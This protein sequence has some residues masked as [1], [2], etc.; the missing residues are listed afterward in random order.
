M[1]CYNRRM[2]N[3]TQPT[4]AP[5]HNTQQRPT[6]TLNP[7]PQRKEPMASTKAPAA[8]TTPAKSTAVSAMARLQAAREK[9]AAEGA[10]LEAEAA[11][12]KTQYLR[13]V[14]DELHANGFTAVQLVELETTKTHKTPRKAKSDK[15]AMYRNADGLTWTG[16]GKRP[17]WLV[18]ALKE[19][20][21]LEDFRIN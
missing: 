11:A 14:L 21:T 18:A 16:F 6:L 1:F 19:G 20:K 4:P 12:L 8:D 13:E 15:P 2:S 9:H 10:R 5:L 17:Q 7:P 3:I